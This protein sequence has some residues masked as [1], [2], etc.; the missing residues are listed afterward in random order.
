MLPVTKDS[1]VVVRPDRYAMA[2]ATIS[3]PADIARLASDV[4]KLVAG[5][6]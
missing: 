6:R 2:A 5:S 3:S 1:L 4:R